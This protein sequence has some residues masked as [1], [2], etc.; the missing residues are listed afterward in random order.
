M[1]K[2][3]DWQPELSDDAVKSIIRATIASAGTSDPNELPFKVKERL[4]GQI[5]GDI[6][7]D[8]IIRDVLADINKKN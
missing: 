4:R 2:K 3:T 1:S 7:I 6:D 5:S 8:Q